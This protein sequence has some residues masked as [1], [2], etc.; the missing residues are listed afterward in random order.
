MLCCS[1]QAPAAATRRRLRAGSKLKC[2]DSSTN[3]PGT[4]GPIPNIVLPP[5]PPF[6]AQKIVGSSW[7]QRQLP[8]RPKFELEDS[9][10]QDGGLADGGLQG[11]S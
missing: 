8:K 2:G 10:W 4:D 3:A 6:M 7:Q 5:P 9:E 1:Y 11:W